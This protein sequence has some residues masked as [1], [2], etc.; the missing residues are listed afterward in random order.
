MSRKILLVTYHFPPSPAVG[1]IRPAKFA[2]Y[3]PEFGWTPVVL[4]IR[5]EKV[6]N[7][8]HRGLEELNGTRIVRSAVWPNLVQILN[9]FRRSTKG[10]HENKEENGKIP[11][12]ASTRGSF[13][14][15]ILERK[16]FR[17]KK[18]HEIDV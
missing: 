2:K 6:K 3:L 8:D 17:L 4:T 14:D 7:P 13:R 12:F 9:Y 1:G 15:G 5:E 11:L 18:I 16:A 10:D